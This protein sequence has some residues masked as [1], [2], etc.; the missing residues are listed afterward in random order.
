MSLPIRHRTEALPAIDGLL[1]PHRGALGADYDGYRNHGQRMALFALALLGEGWED[2]V[3][4]AAAFHDL[5]IWTAKTWDYL[6]P[7]QAL[8]R[9]HLAKIGRGEWSDEIV[10]AI[11]THHKITACEPSGS[12]LPEAFRRADAIDLS[13]GLV[14]FGLERN[15]LRDVRRIFPNAGFHRRLVLLTGRALATT[16]WRPLPMMRL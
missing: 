15:F 1:A 14:A 3:A 8:A 9:A 13:L 16:P 12:P 2:K 5:G 7:S 6:D 4:I 11:E 10:G